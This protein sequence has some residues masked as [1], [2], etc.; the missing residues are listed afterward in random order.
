MLHKKIIILGPPCVGKT[1]L[2]NLALKHKIPS[3]ST[4]HVIDR[5]EFF[6]DIINLDIPLFFD[7]GGLTVE[8]INSISD[9][10][11]F[12]I[13]IV[14]LLPSEEVYSQRKKGEI[15]ENPEREKYILKW[16]HTYYQFKEQKSF[17]DL[18]IEDDISPQETLD[19]IIETFGFEK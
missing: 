13:K 17:F 11:E 15:A 12:N 3:F 18:V 5:D 2:V 14:L 6:I 7:A 8:Y 10:I 16:T 1:T 19:Y 4:H 9:N